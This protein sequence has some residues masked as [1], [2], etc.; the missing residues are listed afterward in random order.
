VTPNSHISITDPAGDNAEY[1]GLGAS[2]FLVRP[3]GDPTDV[4]GQLS[5]TGVDDFDSSGLPFGPGDFTGGFQWASVSIPPGG[6]QTYTV[7]LAVNTPAVPVE[8]MGLAIE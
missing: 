8:L 5:D 7:I 3:F 1:R 2:A 6:Q 4:A